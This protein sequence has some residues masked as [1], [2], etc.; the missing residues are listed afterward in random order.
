M[1][2]LSR[3]SAREH[4]F[5]CSTCKRF[6]GEGKRKPNRKTCSSCLKKSA[7]RARSRRAPWNVCT[8]SRRTERNQFGG[9]FCSSCKCVKQPE[10]FLGSHK[11]C[12]LCLL[13]RRSAKKPN[14]SSQ[15]NDLWFNEVHD[16]L[17]EHENEFVH[18]SE[19]KSA[20][21]LMETRAE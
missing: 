7:E 3:M 12:R 11:S 20:H 17:S 18:H 6:L 16:V 8:K 10:N 19:M 5:F 14:M 15:S 21:F 9:R 2:L 1:G 13:R 4:V